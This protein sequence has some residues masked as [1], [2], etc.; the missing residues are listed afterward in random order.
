MLVC[1]MIYLNIV[2]SEEQQLENE[3]GALAYTELLTLGKAST[4][5][6][7]VY[8]ASQIT[9]D[10]PLFEGVLALQREQYGD[11]WEALK[12]LA[13]AGD[14][15][16]MF[17]FAETINGSSIIASRNAGIWFDKAAQLGNPYAALQL[18][19]RTSN[20]EHA[21][22]GLSI[23]RE[24]WI[25][26]ASAMFAER[27]KSGAPMSVFYDAIS[28]SMWGDATDYHTKIKL[29]TKAAK[30][31]YYAPLYRAIY[32][33]EKYENITPEK[34]QA[35]VDLLTLAANNN[36]IPAMVRVFYKYPETLDEKHKIQLLEN[37][38]K[39]GSQGAFISIRQFYIESAKSDNDSNK[40]IIKAYKY[41][42]VGDKLFSSDTINLMDYILNHYGVDDI[43]DAEKQQARVAAD[44]FIS[45][46]T[47]VIYIDEMHPTYW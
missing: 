15:D 16:A 34:R 25:G 33:I 44:K 30:G 45:E 7:D 13:E 28:Y 37:T 4:P 8:A 24:K 42:F 43:T 20:C 1:L 2:P 6:P 41:V 14:P 35:I 36:F 5:N 11:A 3:Y 29:V 18:M 10:N 21:G 31:G 22:I 39:L 23:C 17:W 12:P 47:P 32:R 27:A 46:M 40:A 38:T 19:P 9:P 26:K